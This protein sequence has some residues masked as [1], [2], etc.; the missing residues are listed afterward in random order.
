MTYH[1]A[2]ILTLLCSLALLY[3]I[4]RVKREVRAKCNYC[5]GDFVCAGISKTQFRDFVSDISNAL[6]LDGYDSVAYGFEMIG[7]ACRVY[8]SDSVCDLTA[9]DSLDEFEEHLEWM[10]YLRV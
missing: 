4:I 7:G 10:L 6:K 2:T 1:T 9:W 8:V 3:A 5:Y